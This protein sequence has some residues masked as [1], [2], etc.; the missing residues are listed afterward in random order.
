MLVSLERFQEKILIR[1]SLLENQKNNIEKSEFILNEKYLSKRGKVKIHT[2]EKVQ[3]QKEDAQT[4]K[5]VLKER[6]YQ[7]D[8]CLIRILKKKKEIKHQN[9]VQELFELLQLPVDV[10]YAQST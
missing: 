1:K 5:R 4:E 3:K 10:L 9:L 2:V 7:I 8:A 6:N